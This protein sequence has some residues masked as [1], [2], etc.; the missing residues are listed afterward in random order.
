MD[1]LGSLNWPT[2]AAILGVVAI[3]TFRPQLR[4]LLSRTKKLGKTGLETYEQSQLPKAEEKPV[5][6]FLESFANPLLVEQETLIL[7]DLEKQ[8]LS[9]AE[10]A[11]RALTRALAGTQI[12]L[13]FETV[14]AQIWVQ[15]R[16][17][18]RS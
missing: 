11:K 5:D 13:H 7:A 9:D 4:D 2:A 1:I 14:F 6:Q 12:V 10:D 3:F 16:G 18:Y 8:G 15:R 17:D